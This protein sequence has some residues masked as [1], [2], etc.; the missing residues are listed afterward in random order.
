[1]AAPT[2][3][4]D[5]TTSNPPPISI[6]VTSPS[7]IQNVHHHISEKL[8]QDN[9]I[10]WQFL[11]VPF[12]EGHNLFGYVD[13]TFPQPPKL[14]PDRTSGLLILNPD[15]SPWYHQDR[16]IFNAIIS[17]LSVETLPHVIG[18]TTSREV[19]VTLETLF[20]TQSKSRILQLKQQLSN[21]KK[22]AQTVSAYFQKVQGIANLVA[23]IGKPVEDSELIS[24]IL[25]RLGADYDPIVTSVT[26]RQDSISLT[27]LNGY[28]LSYELRLETHKTALDI[29]M[30]TANTAQRQSPSYP[31]NNRGSN[32]GYRNTNFSSGRGRGHGRGPPHQYSFSGP[33]QCP[34]CQVCHKLGHTAATCWFW[35]EQG[36]QSESSPL[37]A[38]LAS[39]PTAS[40]SQ[41]YHDTGSNVHLTNEL[42]NLN[43]HAENYNGTDQIRVGNGQGLHISNSG[44][45]LLPTP[46]RNF[47]LFSLF[48]VPQIQKNLIS[49]NQFTRDNHV[50]IEFHPTFFYVKDLQTRQLLLQG[51][52][53]L[54]LYPWPS[55]AAAS[56]RSPTVF[57][58]EKVSLD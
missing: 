5:S 44:R 26:T 38:N 34:T 48:H 4:T 17:T 51:P 57:L 8:T 11:M 46:S 28:M 2:S 54:G 29:N 30:S 35:F 16:I 15:H 41:W 31:R 12:L 22:D 27:D 36:Y 32:T 19:W 55:F 24:N 33:S 45:G 9:Y 7:L 40:D 47:H 58:G 21:L 52:S 3:E 1:M 25:A 42:A 6:P 18:L 23:A 20:A 50:F 43:M 13:G 53:K 14:I 56:S 37:N 39:L 49:V 10:L